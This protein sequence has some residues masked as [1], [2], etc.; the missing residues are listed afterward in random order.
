[1]AEG[2]DSKNLITVNVKTPKS[3]EQIL[4]HENAEI[5]D[6]STIGIVLYWCLVQEQVL[7]CSSSW[8]D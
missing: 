6:V 2:M 3:K 5:K 7:G 8:A 1:M 4:V